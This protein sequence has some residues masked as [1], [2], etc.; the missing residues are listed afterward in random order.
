MDILTKVFAVDA[1]PPELE[2]QLAAV[3]QREFSAEL[4]KYAPADWYVVGFLGHELVG[5]AGVVKRVIAVGGQTLEVGGIT[6]VVTEPDYRKRGV[7]RTLIARGMEFL[8]DEHQVSLA[9]LTCSRQLGSLYERLGW[10]V[11]QGP[12]VYAQPDGPRT[13]SGL[14]MVMESDCISWPDGPIDLQGLPW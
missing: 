3:Y 10:R 12:T 1:L 8:R 7:A 6:G 2:T 9:L 13:C 5:H 14:T 11:V 4:L